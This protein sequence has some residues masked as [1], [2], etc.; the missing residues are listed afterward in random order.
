VAITGMLRQ[1]NREVPDILSLNISN[2]CNM[3]QPKLRMDVASLPQAVR[4]LVNAACHSSEPA[5]AI[6]LPHATLI[7]NLERSKKPAPQ[8]CSRFL[9]YM[10]M[11]VDDRSLL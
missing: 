5:L 9:F 1:A 4:S 3:Q 10:H 6:P 7:A 2:R 11:Y 8:A